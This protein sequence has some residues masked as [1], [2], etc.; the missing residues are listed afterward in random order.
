V[1]LVV[2]G[3]ALFASGAAARRGA[4]APRDPKQTVP[5]VGDALEIRPADPD[6]LGRNWQAV[7][8]ISPGSSQRRIMSRKTGEFKGT[9]SR[10][11]MITWVKKRDNWPWENP[12]ED[13]KPPFKLRFLRQDPAGIMMSL[14]AEGKLQISDGQY[15]GRKVVRVSLSKPKPWYRRIF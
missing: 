10:R 11:G 15:K 4:R 14:A 8:V 9:N 5:T 6:Y 12:W 2:S 1:L 7:S 13:S 3:C